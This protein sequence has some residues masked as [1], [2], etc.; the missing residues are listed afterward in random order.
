VI[1]DS[2]RSPKSQA[3]LIVLV[4]FFGY[5][6]F[7]RFYVGKVGTGLLQLCTLG[8]FYIWVLIDFVLII[9]GKFKDK[10]GRY[11]R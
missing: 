7:H 9:C 2:A 4:F 11:V 8:G 3:A 5:L 10:E 6:G 1:L